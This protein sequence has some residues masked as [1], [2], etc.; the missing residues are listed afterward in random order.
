VIKGGTSGTEE[1]ATASSAGATVGGGDT[2][3]KSKKAVKKE[4][5][6]AAASGK[7]A[8]EVLKPSGD[9]KLPPPTTG[10]GD[11]CEKGTAGCSDSGEFNGNFFE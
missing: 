7:G 1:T 2:T 4:K 6:A 3:G 10:I 8:E 11:K 5:Q 9:V